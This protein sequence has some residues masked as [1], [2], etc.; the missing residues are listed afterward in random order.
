MESA[1][2][3]KGITA[4]LIYYDITEYFLEYSRNISQQVEGPQR[5]STDDTQNMTIETITLDTT[6]EI[7]SSEDDEKPV[8]VC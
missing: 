1:S 2:E 4:S 7:S 8:D 6:V 3:K 5:A